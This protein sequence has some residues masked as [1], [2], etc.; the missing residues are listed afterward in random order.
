MHHYGLWY[1]YWYRVMHKTILRNHSV[2]DIWWC[3][4]IAKR[5][6]LACIEG[7]CKLKRI[8]PSQWLTKFL[9]GACLYQWMGQPLDGQWKNVST[10]CHNPAFRVFGD[11]HLPKLSGHLRMQ[12]EH[13]QLHI[14]HKKI[15]ANYLVES[16]YN[17]TLA[18]LWSS[19]C[20]AMERITLTWDYQQ[21][22][23]IRISKEKFLCW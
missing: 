18:L 3:M 12:W 4:W 8:L 20:P 22:C 14:R 15:A 1:C 11:L 10:S 16:L 19:F 7:L 2:S 21:Q 9:L 6:H 17:T 23:A 13:F 5:K